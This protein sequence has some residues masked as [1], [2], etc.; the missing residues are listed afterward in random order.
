VRSG[1]T[2]I[3]CTPG[4]FKA[5]ENGRHCPRKAPAAPA[6]L[7][8]FSRRAFDLIGAVGCRDQGP[9]PRQLQL[10]PRRSSKEKAGST[11]PNAS[12]DQVI[13]LPHPAITCTNW[14]AGFR[15]CFF[16]LLLL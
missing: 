6:S 12:C 7:D 14:K 1:S 11:P 4:L 9:T 8:L 5:F 15:F 13:F 2:R 3:D 10:G 16:L